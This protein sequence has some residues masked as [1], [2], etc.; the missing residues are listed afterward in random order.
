M[1]QEKNRVAF[2]SVITAKLLTGCKLITLIAVRI[3]GKP[4]GKE[5]HYGHGKV[6]NQSALH[7]SNDIRRSSGAGKFEEVCIH[8]K[9]GLSIDEAHPISHHVSDEIKNN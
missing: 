1:V 9:P 5:H 2:V 3:T 8:V 6:E 7:F 4:A